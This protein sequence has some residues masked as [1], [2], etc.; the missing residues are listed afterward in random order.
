MKFSDCQELFF[1]ET[2]LYDE[3][4]G[5]RE[6]SATAFF[7]HTFVH[8]HAFSLKVSIIGWKQLFLSDYSCFSSLCPLIPQH[9]FSSASLVLC[10]I[11]LHGF[12]LFFSTSSLL[13]LSLLPPLSLSVHPSCLFLISL[14]Q[15]TVSVAQGRVRSPSP[16]PR[17]KSYA[18][19][20]AA[21]VK[22]PEQKRRRFT[23]QVR[24]SQR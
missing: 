7:D 18:Y 11:R 17:Y 8:I 24:V 21:Y 15:I 9:T 14:S 12:A 2:T 6:K 4:N 16:Q 1:N 23:D 13:S 22:S 10:I 20:Q 5:L 19:T 3:L